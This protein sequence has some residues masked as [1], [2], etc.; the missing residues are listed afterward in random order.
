LDRRAEGVGRE[1]GEE[2]EEEEEEVVEEVEVRV[3]EE[4]VEVEEEEVEMVEVEEVVDLVVELGF[5]P[6]QLGSR[7]R[8]EDLGENLVEVGEAEEME[9]LRDEATAASAFLASS[10]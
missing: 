5:F 6:L 1:E 3:V 4:V 10:C 8:K 2:G 9:V 7:L